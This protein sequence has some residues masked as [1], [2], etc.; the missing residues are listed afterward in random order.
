MEF[1]PTTGLV[2]FR[3]KLE[4]A[5]LEVHCLSSSED[6]E[7]LG[8]GWCWIVGIPRLTFAHHVNHFDA[9]Q[10]CCCAGL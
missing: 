2:R 8:K 3:G 6:A 4:C 10:Y 7:L 5:T 1:S 9:G